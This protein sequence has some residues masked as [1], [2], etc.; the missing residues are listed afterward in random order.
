MTGSSYRLDELGWLQFD[1][2][3][4]LVLE[5]D[6]GLSGLEWSGRGDGARVARVDGPLTLRDRGHRLGGPVTVAGVWVRG[7]PVVDLRL[8]DFTDRVVGLPAHRTEWLLVLTNLDSADARAAL[9]A[10]PRARDLCVMVLGAAELSVSLDRDPRLRVAMPSVLGLRDL[11][12]L[13]DSDVRDRSSLDVDQAQELARVFWPTQ[14]YDRARDV[15]G[16][17]RFVVLTGPPEMGKTAIAEMLALAYLTDGWEAHQCNDPEQVWRVFDRERRQ[18]F[19]ADDAFGSTEYRPDAAERWGWGLGRLLE[20]L[21]AQ[22]WL[23]WTSRPAPL[24]AGLRQVQRERGSERF[25]APAEV[26]VDAGD[27]DLADKTLILFRHAKDHGAAGPARRV[28][29]SAGLSIVEH[30]HFTPERIRRFVTDRLD[31]LRRLVADDERQM[32]RMIEEELASPTEAMRTSFRALES[33]HRELLISLLDAPAGLIDERE[34]ASVVRRHHAGGLSRP[35]G[36]LVDRLTDHFL[37]V[38]PLGIGWVHPSWRDLVIDELR[39]DR[40]ARRRF[41]AVSG[42]DGVTLAISAAGGSTGERTLP[43]LIDDADWDALGD[44]LHELRPELEDRELARVLLSLMG[45]I[46]V[47]GDAYQARELES[48]AANVLR[49]SRRAWDERHGPVPVFLL[50]AW[51]GLNACLAESAV[52]PQLAPTWAELHP[53]GLLLEH[54]D[55]A[56]LARTEEWL[57]FAEV[58]RRHDIVALEWFGFY[59]TDRDLLERLIVSLTRT[60]ADEEM[61]PLTESVLARIERLV[62]GL[63]VGAQSAREIGRLVEGLGRRRWWVPEDLAA[64]PSTEPAIAGT[65]DFHREDVDRVL[66][67]L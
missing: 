30:P 51:Y 9:H 40:I 55:P 25:P 45:A 33:E 57:E 5:A 34:L 10:D 17:H 2:T 65:S 11:D 38:T 4:S 31:E 13:I 6:A 48:L 3:C 56:E 16:R 41:L 61:R 67:D 36:D 59:T 66:R 42:V 52:R 44:R 63:A 12:G 32:L 50:E 7:A 18:V 21:D 60:S 8:S 1:R 28:V 19:I 14:A 53:G 43:L 47:V 27:L 22:H 64:P 58:L 49:T 23:I 26:L 20:M 35:V 29:R 46:A 62:P 37:R 15:L 54:P 39:E 24:K